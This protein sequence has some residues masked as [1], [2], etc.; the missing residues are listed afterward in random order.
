MATQTAID[1]AFQVYCTLRSASEDQRV[2]FE[3][4]VRPQGIEIYRVVR[5]EVT[6]AVFV[7]SLVAYVDNR[8]N[9]FLPSKTADG[10]Q[11][12]IRMTGD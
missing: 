5:S 3:P 6:N 9:L 11:C 7:R 1:K 4:E 2:I 8:G 10:T 12:L